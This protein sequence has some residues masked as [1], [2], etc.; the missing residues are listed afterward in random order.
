MVV[1][2]RTNVAAKNAKLDAKGLVTNL[3][4]SKFKSI[5]VG[6]HALKGS[7]VG[8]TPLIEPGVAVTGEL[9]PMNFGSC[10][11]SSSIRHPSRPT[12]I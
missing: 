9:P 5:C 6:S 10:D 4:S 12:D 1:V 11:Q 2:E 8:I 3:T 7:L